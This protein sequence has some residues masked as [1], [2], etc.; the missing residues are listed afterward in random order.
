[1]WYEPQQLSIFVTFS[2]R[3]HPGQEYVETDYQS[4]KEPSGPIY[5]DTGW[6]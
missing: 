3:T 4:G 2:P 6:N 5:P 1:M